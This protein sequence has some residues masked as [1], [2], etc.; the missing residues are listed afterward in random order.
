MI[1]PPGQHV[2][3]RRYSD[4][5]PLKT[6]IAVLTQDETKR[7]FAAI[8]TTRDHALFLTTSHHGL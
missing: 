8:S 6:T 1:I 4:E 7:L 2:H 3:T 5:L